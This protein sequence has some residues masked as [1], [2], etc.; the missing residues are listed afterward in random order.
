MGTLKDE[1]TNSSL[2]SVAFWAKL[3][4]HVSVLTNIWGAWKSCL[5][6]YSLHTCTEACYKCKAEK[7]SLCATF[8]SRIQSW[9]T[10]LMFVESLSCV[11]WWHIQHISVLSCKWYTVQSLSDQHLGA[12]HWKRTHGDNQRLWFTGI[13]MTLIRLCRR[14][15][16][17]PPLFFS[18]VSA[19]HLEGDVTLRHLTEN[20][21]YSV[22]VTLVLSLPSNPICTGLH[23]KW[24]IWSHL[25]N[26]I[27]L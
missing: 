22:Q 3:P 9:R 13:W 1:Y 7:P 26:K 11:V 25:R 24:C 21:Y 4:V 20:I 19:A 6:L 18:A 23:F 2:K 16:Q 15:C 5:M 17:K 14:C 27:L 10:K 8:W 12:G